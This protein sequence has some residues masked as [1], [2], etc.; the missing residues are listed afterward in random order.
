MS[1]TINRTP[2]ALLAITLA[3]SAQGSAA[4]LDPRTQSCKKAFLQCIDG[5]PERGPDGRYPLHLERACND[6]FDDCMSGGALQP[7]SAPELDD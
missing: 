5:V 2:P 7:T 4:D 3:L 1:R 6:D